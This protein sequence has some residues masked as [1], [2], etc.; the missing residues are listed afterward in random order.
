MES[1]FR[2]EYKGQ[3]IDVDRFNANAEIAKWLD[4]NNIPRSEFSKVKF[5][6]Q[7][8]KNGGE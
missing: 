7:M 8:V 5:V 2:F 3:I 4:D 1:W 6:T